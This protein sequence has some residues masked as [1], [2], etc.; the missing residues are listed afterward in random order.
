MRD[1][2]GRPA[3]PVT[4]G[5]PAGGASSSTRRGTEVFLQLE[6]DRR[7]RLQ[8]GLSSGVFQPLGKR[9]VRGLAWF[10]AVLGGDGVVVVAFVEELEVLA[11]GTRFFEAAV[12]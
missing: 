1:E 2:G 9:W 6:D 8:D 3:G 10:Q 7:R 4:A 5:P 11:A 12:G